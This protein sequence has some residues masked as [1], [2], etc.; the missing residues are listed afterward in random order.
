MYFS[1]ISLSFESE[2]LSIQTKHIDQALFCFS[3]MDT[4]KHIVQYLADLKK[5]KNS[6]SMNQS[7]WNDHFGKIF[8]FI[9][10][11]NTSPFETSI[12]VT[13]LDAH[14]GHIKL[15]RGKSSQFKVF[16]VIWQHLKSDSYPR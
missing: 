5:T 3:D 2:F 9:K 14:K 4:R 8:C 12:L 1:I 7:L 16:S 10:K 6:F 13:I 15:M 11:H